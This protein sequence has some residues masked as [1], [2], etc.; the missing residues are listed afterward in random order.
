MTRKK[1]RHSLFVLFVG[2]VVSMSGFFVSLDGI[3]GCGKSTQCRLLAE[4]L[5]RQGRAVTECVDPGGTPVGREVRDLLLSHRHRLHRNCEALLF[6]ASRA[7]LVADVIRPALDRGEVVVSDRYLLA[8]V[9][10]Q[11]HGSGVD[12]DLLWTAGRLATE[13][14][15]PDLTIVLDLTAEAAL[16]RRDRPADR[17]ESREL[18]YH[19]RVREGFLTEA[20]RRPER[21]KVLDATR[22]VERIHEDVCQ[23]VARVMATS[24]RA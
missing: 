3:D 6:M 13:A 14:L 11:G 15:E 1:T 10:Y 24:Q 8:T 9:A 2:S 5:R 16:A 4:W 22:A 7:Q 12:V 20:R 21:V 17:L 18:A 19:Q 23:E